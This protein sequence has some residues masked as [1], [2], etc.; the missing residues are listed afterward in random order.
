MRIRKVGEQLSKSYSDWRSYLE[1]QQELTIIK[2]KLIPSINNLKD[3]LESVSNT[4]LGERGL[5]F[6]M[7]K[8]RNKTTD[9][10]KDMLRFLNLKQFRR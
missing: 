8:L 4:Y 3:R 2:K 10:K 9:L 6:E 1:R 5:Y 7:E